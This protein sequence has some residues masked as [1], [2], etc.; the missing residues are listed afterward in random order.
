M[1]AG[2]GCSSPE[3]RIGYFVVA[4]EA[5]LFETEIDNLRFDTWVD[6][7][8][9][10]EAQKIALYEICNKIIVNSKG[11]S[12]K[13]CKVEFTGNL[14]ENGFFGHLGKYK[15]QIV[16]SDYKILAEK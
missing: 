6:D 15:Q 5:S 1:S 13:Y 14:E 10:D 4:E 8:E 16:L 11:N 3:K 2:F 7:S 12:Y 9:L